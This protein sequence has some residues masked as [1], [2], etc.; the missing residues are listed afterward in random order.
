MAEGVAGRTPRCAEVLDLAAELLG[1]VAADLALTLGARGGVYIGG[2]LV[3]RYA[4]R[5][6]ASGFRR[7]FENKGRFSK[8][9]AAI[10][11]WLVLHEHPALLGLASLVREPPQR[12]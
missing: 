5:F 9:L 6:V 12:S 11:T 4:R 10:P 1:T 7:R 8:Y 2:G 3:P